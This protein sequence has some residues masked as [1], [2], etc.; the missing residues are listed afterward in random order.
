MQN[1]NDYTD[2]IESAQVAAAEAGELLKERWQL[3]KNL[4]QKGF[5][6]WVTDTDIEAQKIITGIL[7]QRHAGH[8]FLAE[9]DAGPLPEQGAVTWVID[10][11]DGTTNFSRQQPNFCI[12]IAAAVEGEAVAGVIL[13]PLR[14]EWFCATS[15]SPSTL[16]GDP[17]VVSDT[18]ALDDA[19]IALDWAHGIKVRQATVDSLQR[20]GNDVRTVRSIGSAA[21]ALAWVAAGRL[22]AYWNWSLNAWDL[23]AGVLIIRQAQGHCTTLDNLPLHAVAGTNSC[24]ASNGIL[25]EHML[26]R[27]AL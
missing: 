8:A 14:Q 24:L 6:D 19:V 27:I 15:H 21:L 12:S 22:D 4:K 18:P 26:R 3:P 13:D 25:H 23:A 10:P 16:N 9:E 11:I 20:L 2:L 7:Q 5:R 1:A 17:I